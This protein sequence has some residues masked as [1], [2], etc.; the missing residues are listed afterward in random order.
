MSYTKTGVSC[1]KINYKIQSRAV[2][3]SHKKEMN[4]DSY[5]DSHFKKNDKTFILKKMNQHI[6]QLAI[7]IKH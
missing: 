2:L 7:N 1:K 6:L 4:I 3:Q 5:K